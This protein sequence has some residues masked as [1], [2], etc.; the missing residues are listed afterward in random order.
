MI[1]GSVS[2]RVR[3]AEIRLYDAECAL[4]AAHQTG[5][6][7]WILA[8]S[9]KL[10]DAVVE[11]LAAVAEQRSAAERAPR[12]LRSARRVRPTDRRS[13]RRNCSPHRTARLPRRAQ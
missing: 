8:A 6:G 10:H 7:V 2:D 13:E 5:V 11:H 9:A 12:R 1:T 3:A 4:H